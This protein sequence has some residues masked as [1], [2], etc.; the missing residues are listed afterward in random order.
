MAVDFPWVRLAAIKAAKRF[1]RRRFCPSVYVDT[2]RHPFRG[3]VMC[4][5][6]ADNLDE[7]HAMADKIGMERRWFQSPPKASHPH[8]DIP[9][10][11]RAR[12][13]AL[14]AQEVTQRAGLHYAA[15]AINT[16]EQLRARRSMP[17]RRE[18]EPSPKKFYFKI[19]VRPRRGR[20]Y[21]EP[22]CQ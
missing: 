4:H 14:G 1:R 7:L 8:Y 22:Y 6:I 17:M 19:H 11:K 15:A 13:L 16:A 12:A 9:E 5:M 3:Y 2:A 18:D 21:L 10:G 20:S